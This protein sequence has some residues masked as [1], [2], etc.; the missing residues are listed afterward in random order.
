[1][2]QVTRFAICS[3]GA[4]VLLAPATVAWQET[5]Q[6]EVT[7][8]GVGA[9]VVDHRLQG[10]GDSFPEG[11]RVAYWTRV[12]GGAE[13]DRIYHVWKHGET[14]VRIGLNIGGSHWRTH[15]YKTLYV[16]SS[17]EW[18]VEARDA[19]DRVLSTKTFQCVASGGSD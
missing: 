7:E 12:V 11:S 18:V 2:T 17:G 15:S 19:D 10:A 13:G 4:L 16:G 5:G 9:E 14:E 1:M 3:L 8:D 6:L